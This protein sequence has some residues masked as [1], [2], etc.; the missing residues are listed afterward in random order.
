MTTVTP[1]GLKIRPRRMDFSLSDPLPRHWH[2][3]DPFKTHFFNS[4]SVLFPDGERY[5]IDSVRLFRD[6]ITDPELLEQIRGF[7]G[8]EGHHSREHIEYNQRLRD[9]GYDIDKLEIPV[10][11]RIRF[12]QKQFSAERQLAGTVAMEH[13]TAI[14]ADALLREPEWMAGA[15]PEMQKLWRWHALEETEHKA[16]AFDVYMKVCGDRQILRRAMRQATFFFLKDVTQGMWHM[17]R[18]DGK[19]GD[20]K[21]MVRGMRWLWGRN[22]FFTRLVGVY[23]DYYRTDFHPWQHDNMALLETH[24]EEFSAA[25]I[26]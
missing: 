6:Q 12:V 18:R 8:Q 7:I 22:G 15:T 19:L 10:R 23:R 2:S 21:M 17:L 4:M 1:S 25:L 11:K 3:G 16:V 5:F 20:V 26:R 9:L 24:S 14:L 13:F